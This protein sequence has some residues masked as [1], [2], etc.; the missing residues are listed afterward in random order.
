[1]QGL[2]NQMFGIFGFL[3]VVIQLIFQIMPVFVTQ[4]TLYEASERPSKTYDW[5]AFMISS[6]AVELS[7]NSVSLSPTTFS[8]YFHS[9]STNMYLPVN[10]DI[11]FSYMVLS[12]WTLEQR[13]SD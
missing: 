5:R 2:Q 4:R 12:D 8:S 7:W 13:C 10:C 1:M 3:F 9:L 6:I 11:L